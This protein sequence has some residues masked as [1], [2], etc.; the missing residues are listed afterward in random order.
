MDVRLRSYGSAGRENDERH[1]RSRDWLLLSCHCTALS[2]RTARAA[3][4][5]S[6]RASWRGGSGTLSRSTCA[7]LHDSRCRQRSSS[8]I[9]HHHVKG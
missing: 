9:S 8:R 4:A 6:G 2:A 1:R 7:R 3:S 5:L